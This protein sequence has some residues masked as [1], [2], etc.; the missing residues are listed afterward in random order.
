MWLETISNFLHKKL[1]KNANFVHFEKLE[2]IDK[3]N[4]SQNTFVQ[5]QIAFN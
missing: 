1:Y 2:C 4:A 3:Q 5:L